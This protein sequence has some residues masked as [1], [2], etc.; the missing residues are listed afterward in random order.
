MDHGSSS[1]H[2]RKEL[3]DIQR[4]L[5]ALTVWDSFRSLDFFSG[6]RDKGEKGVCLSAKGPLLPTA[7]CV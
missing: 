3:G 2:G 6:D 7:L 4:L 1:A 5:L